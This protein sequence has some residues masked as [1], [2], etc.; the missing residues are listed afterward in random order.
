L[1]SSAHS[2]LTPLQAEVLEAFFQRERGFFLTGGLRLLVF[3][4]DTEQRTT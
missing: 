4:W 1:T 2:K 3:T